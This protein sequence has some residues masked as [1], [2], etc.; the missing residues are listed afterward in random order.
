M[1]CDKTWSGM[2]DYPLVARLGEPNKAIMHPGL[3]C[4]ILLGK[5]EKQVR[6]P[7][8]IPARVSVVPYYLGRDW[9]LLV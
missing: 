9:I 1:V 4:C 3:C 7:P 2:A 6:V 5:A 8:L